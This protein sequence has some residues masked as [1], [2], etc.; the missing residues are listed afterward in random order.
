MKAGGWNLQLRP[1]APISLRQ[2]LGF[3]TAVYFASQYQGVLTADD[4]RAR[5]FWGGLLTQRAIAAGR[6][7]GPGLAGF[8]IS[9]KAQTAYIDE[10]AGLPAAPF[11]FAQLV[12]AMCTATATSNGIGVGTGYSASATTVATYDPTSTPGLKSVLDAVSALT[13]NEYRITPAGLIDWGVPSTTVAPVRYQDPTPDL[14]KQRRVVISPDFTLPGDSG[15]WWLIQP[16]TWTPDADINDYRNGCVVFD[17]T[18]TTYTN[19]VAAGPDAVTFDR[20]DGTGVVAYNNDA[21]IKA[22][23]ADAGDMANLAAAGAELYA[24]PQYSIDCQIDLYCPHRLFIPGDSIYAYDPIEGLVGTTHVPI[25]GM[26][27]APRSIRVLG[28]AVPVQD[29]M[30]VYAIDP[31]DRSIVRDLTPYITWETGTT[32]LTLGSPPVA[33]AGARTQSLIA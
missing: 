33:P 4:V 32:A 31:H 1:D 10:F 6:F 13:G 29:G 22:P 7:S 26:Q 14:Y 9:G 11:T 12:V 2:A 5:A 28:M 30:G 3:G 27:I 16:S 19:A 18:G 15:G 20:L 23:S 17:D 8:M 24:A 21:Q 25:P